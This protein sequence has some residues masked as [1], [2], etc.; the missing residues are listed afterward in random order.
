MTIFTFISHVDRCGC[1]ALNLLQSHVPVFIEIWD[2][3]HAL[4]F[5]RGIHV[6]Y[7]WTWMRFVSISCGNSS[8]TEIHIY[9][10]TLVFN[11]ITIIFPFFFLLLHHRGKFSLTSYNCDTFWSKSIF[12]W[13]I[14]NLIITNIIYT[15]VWNLM[16]SEWKL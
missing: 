12:Y 6:Q 14:I 16:T 2:I 4:R 13:S 11:T 8:K 7:R 3:A 1:C 5:H 15:S 9:S 10:G